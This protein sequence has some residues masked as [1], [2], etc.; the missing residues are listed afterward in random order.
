MTPLLTKAKCGESLDDNNCHPKML[1]LEETSHFHKLY[2]GP[3]NNLMEY[4]S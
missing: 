1:T 2:N 4:I 3:Q